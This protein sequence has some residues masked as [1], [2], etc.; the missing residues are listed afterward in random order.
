MVKYSESLKLMVVREYLNG[1][2]GYNHLARKYDIKSHNQLLNWMYIYKE[3][4]VA[5]LFRKK[6]KE[7]Y[8]VQVKLDV[9]SFMKKTG[10]SQSDTAHQFGLTNAPIIS[11][12]MKNFH[13]G[14]TEALDRLRGRPS[15]V[16]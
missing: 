13:E 14:G 2:L 7:V 1:I 5:G 3:H 11:S 10:A 4:G 9:L 16:L 6:I 15:P 12:W 8:S